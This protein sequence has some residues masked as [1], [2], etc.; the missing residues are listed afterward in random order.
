MK[1]MESFPDSLDADIGSN[2]DRPEGQ[3]IGLL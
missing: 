1:V 2:F 3:E